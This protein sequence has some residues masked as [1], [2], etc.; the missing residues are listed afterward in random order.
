MRPTADFMPWWLDANSRFDDCHTPDELFDETARLTAALGFERF[1]WGR[2]RAVPF[3]QAQLQCTGT[4]PAE[5]LAAAHQLPAPGLLLWGEGQ[6]AVGSLRAFGYA[7][8]ASFS[9]RGRDGTWQLL[10][11][12]RR[13]GSIKLHERLPLKLQL[14]SLLELLDEHLERLEGIHSA[15]TL[16]DR[17]TQVLRWIADGK[18]SKGIADILQLSEHTVNFHIKGIL[19]KFDSP[20]RVQAVAQA[21]ARGLI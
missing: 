1:A 17:E 9:H 14:R 21:A 11:V 12:A 16:S 8:G 5:W 13:K 4:Y 15:I 18:C 3:S 20:N 19:R 10:C 2:R 7:S 6:D